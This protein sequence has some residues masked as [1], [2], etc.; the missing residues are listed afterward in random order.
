M[1]HMVCYDIKAP[2]VAFCS[3]L[4]RLGFKLNGM[5]QWQMLGSLQFRHSIFTA[6]CEATAAAA[7][8]CIRHGCYVHGKRWHQHRAAKNWSS[9]VQQG[10]VFCRRAAANLVQCTRW[11]VILCRISRY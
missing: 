10:R 6:L 2:C 3:S 5:L 4:N 7:I 11:R 9:I 1:R 8:R